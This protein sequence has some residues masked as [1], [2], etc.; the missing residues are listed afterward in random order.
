[1]AA[2]MWFSTGDFAVEETGSILAPLLRWLLPWASAGQITALHV[3][4]RKGAHFTEYAI[5]AALWLRALHRERIGGRRAGLIVLLACA[6]WAFTDELHQ[7]FEPTR[8]ASA[9]DVLLD[10]A[11][12]AVVVLAERLGWRRLVD[13][14]TAAL[15]WTAVIGGGLVLA[16]NAASGAESGPL[17]ITV[18][19][20]LL[21]LVVRW[22][23]HYSRS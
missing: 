9:L 11:G 14:A 2:I 4:L 22:R 3:L 10:S 8:D 12:A 17:W 13:A 18:P 20:A 6:T 23:K 7:A 15:L 16:V 19:V 1:M 5:L 21:A